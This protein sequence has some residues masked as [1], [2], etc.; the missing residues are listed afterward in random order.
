MAADLIRKLVAE[1]TTLP[2]IRSLLSHIHTRLG[3]TANY[4]R[5]IADDVQAAP[6]G[7]SQRMTF[8]NNYLAAI[9]KFGG[10]DDLDGMDREA[11]E[12]EAKRLLAIESLTPEESDADADD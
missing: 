2:D 11:I 1:G 4:A 12:T 5:M 7:S 10:N 8:H 9:A 6:E 3:G